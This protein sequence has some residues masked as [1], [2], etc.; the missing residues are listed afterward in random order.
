MEQ[1]WINQAVFYHIYPIGFCGAPTKNTESETVY[2]MDKLIDWIPHLKKLNINAVYLGPVFESSEHGY[3]TSDYLKIDRRLGD[4]E[5]FKKIC[6]AL[7]DNGIKIVLDG[8]FNHVGREFWAF[9]DVIE[10]GQNSKYC[11]WFHGLNFDYQSPYGDP[12]C[13]DAWE[14][15]F[16]LIKLNLK[17]PEVSNHIL[18][19]VKMWMDEFEIDGIRLDAAD[20]VDPDFFKKLKNL[21][22]SRRSDFWLMGEIIHGDYNMWA[23]PE[24]LDST[25]NYEC[26]K[27]IYSSHNDKNYFEIAHSLN[28]QF[29]DGGIY[30]NIYTY[31]FV[32]NHDVNRLASTIKNSEHLNNVYTLLF[33]MPGAPSI[34]YGSEWALKGTKQNGCDADLRPC[35]NIKNIPEPNLSLESHI[36][37]LGAVHIG[38]EALRIGEYSQVIVRNEQFVYKRFTNNQ[39][40]YVAL[41][42]ANQDSTVEF[43]TNSNKLTDILTGT[44]LTANNNYANICLPKYTSMVL[45]ED[46]GSFDIN[47]LYENLTKEENIDS[48]T[49]TNSNKSEEKKKAPLEERQRK[50]GRYRHFKGAEYELICIAAHSE[51]LEEMVVYRCLDNGKFWVRP[52]SMFF[53]TVEHNG[54]EI[55]R[56]TF[57]D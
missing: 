10:N 45:I 11:D 15:H 42:L 23:N 30:K 24:M 40:V 52:S 57:L 19:A 39:T 32:D 9:L 28:R 22:K 5:S 44:T 8:V 13:Y 41:N 51:T 6:K 33:T 18:D 36:S 29:G 2:R 25:T 38:L 17:N 21:V 31:N 3:D 26:Y 7:H 50:H 53:S 37:K 48:K 55:Y 34:Y 12:F 4:N 1:N 20:C 14:G 46:D 16:N 56:F 43:N 49:E 54:E 27:G 35:L 47:S